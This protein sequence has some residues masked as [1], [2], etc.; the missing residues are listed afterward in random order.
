MMPFRVGETAHPVDVHVGRQIN[1]RRRHLGYNQSDLARALGLTFQQ[2]QKYES[3]TNRISASKLWDTA[4]FLRVDIA[5]FFQGLSGSETAGGE[6]PSAAPTET[7]V[8][9]DIARLSCRL[10]VRQQRNVLAILEDLATP[11]NA[12]G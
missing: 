12:D 3:G 9:R 6:N 1:E 5:F 10:S 4:R 11:P 2:I 8:T 7:R